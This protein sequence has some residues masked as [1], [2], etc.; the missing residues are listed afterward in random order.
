MYVASWYRV[1]VSRCTI[2]KWPSTGIK[3]ELEAKKKPWPGVI[4]FRAVWSGQE[5]LLL[6]GFHLLIAGM[7]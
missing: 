6:L 3:L 2:T 1:L 7:D 4:C 5:V